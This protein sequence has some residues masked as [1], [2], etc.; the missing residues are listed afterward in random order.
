MN[1]KRELGIVI[2]MEWEFSHFVKKKKYF[3]M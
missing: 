3:K 2:N 1:E